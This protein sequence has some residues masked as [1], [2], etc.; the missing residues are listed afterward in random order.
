[1][2][3][4]TVDTAFDATVAL[5]LGI[6]AQGFFVTPGAISATADGTM[7]DLA[8]T[9]DFGFADVTAD[10]DAAVQATATVTPQSATLRLADLQ[11][12]PGASATVAL[13]GAASVD[14]TG[15]AGFGVPETFELDWSGDMT[16]AVVSGPLDLLDGLGNVTAADMQALFDAGAQ[17]L[18]RL[19]SGDLLGDLPVFG[20]DLF[21]SFDPAA[22]L[23]NA[24]DG[25][26][27]TDLDELRAGVLAAA[28]LQDL[29]LRRVDLSGD[30][31]EDGVVFD[32]GYSTTRTGDL[33]VAWTEESALGLEAQ[34]T[35]ANVAATV[36]GQV[37][38]GVDLRGDTPALFLLAGDA[39][40]A[41]RIQ[42][43]ATGIDAA[44]RIGFLDL[45][46]TGGSAQ[47]D[48]TLRLARGDG[49]AVISLAELNGTIVDAEAFADVGG[50][51][52]LSLPI[53]SDAIPGL[54]RT[55]TANWSDLSDL[56]TFSTNAASFADIAD[57]ESLSPDDVLDALQE[58]PRILTQLAD[59][60][61][62][63]DLPVIGDELARIADVA[64][65]IQDALDTIAAFADPDALQAALRAL[66][67]EATVTPGTDALE[68]SLRD[69]Q[70]FDESLSIGINEQ[71]GALG[72]LDVAGTASVEGQSD[73]R[74][75][76]GLLL[77]P[78]LAF[79]DR[80]YLVAGPAATALAL[81]ARVSTPAPFTAGA[82]LAG[83]RLEARNA[84]INMGARQGDGTL[85]PTDGATLSTHL[86]DPG[87]SANDGRATLRELLAAG[88]S[89]FAAPTVHGLIDGST[90][91]AATGGTGAVPV[92]FSWRLDRPQDAPDLTFDEAALTSLL[93]S[94]PADLLTS[95]SL[96]DRRGPRYRPWGRG[97]TSW[98]RRWRRRR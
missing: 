16:Q 40:P 17:F 67:D 89:A 56:S 2:T 50:S 58:L 13:S 81:S 12:G 78:T 76:L 61:F 44:A 93:P 14:I 75:Q 3:A 32:L 47:A 22:W 34:A 66:L 8:A 70:A 51:M 33:D 23:D 53:A 83:F 29:G 25:L 11:A 6:D 86:V 92:G 79:E 26:T 72:A 30:G 60:G 24:L 85:H 27:F 62:A 74:L 43:T 5:Q 73:L 71:L 91:I 46:I 59:S 19:N 69:L 31:L 7:T 38:L 20:D 90:E 96:D 55:L 10:V 37:G 57:W 15:D 95:G 84:Q 98:R 41:I 68:I 87:T 42:A 9:A 63:R 80:V 21:D 77:D 48:V 52:S 82:S 65:D 36:S 49:G 88:G 97:W 39:Q 1:M 45:S 94:N 35:V 64:Q 54:P 4:G 28:D 18:G